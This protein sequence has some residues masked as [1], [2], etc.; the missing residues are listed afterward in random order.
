M[1]LGFDRV[2]LDRVDAYWYY[3][4]QSRET[5]AN[6]MVDFVI[7]LTKYAREQCPGLHSLCR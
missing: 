4:E 5:A 3:Q 6:E 2:Y 1:D 7:A